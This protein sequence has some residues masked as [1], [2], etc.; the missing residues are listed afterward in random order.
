M[1]TQRGVTLPEAMVTIAIV[2]ILAGIAL[3]NY[4][5]Y[6][7][8]STLSEAF[9]GLS[10]YRLRMEQAFHNNGNFGAGACAV[11]TP[12]PTENF[13]FACEL[14]DGGQGYLARA[15]GIGRMAGF[16][17]SVDDDG[18]RVTGAF[19]GQG[20]LPASCWLSKKGEC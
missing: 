4:Q 17:F 20:A 2:G 3:P 10:A 19:P 16:A 12:T 14:T 1:R 7:Q 5:G 13:T 9:D 6:I 11:A 18:R 15:D 8:R